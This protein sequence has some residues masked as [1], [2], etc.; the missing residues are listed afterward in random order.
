MLIPFII[1]TVALGWIVVAREAWLWGKRSLTV[2]AV[3]VSLETFV[4]AF[5]CGR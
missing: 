1:L 5:L 2:L 4:F 3:V